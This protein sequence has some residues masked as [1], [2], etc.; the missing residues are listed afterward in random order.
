MSNTINNS[1]NLQEILNL[2]CIK[3]G[4]NPKPAGKTNLIRCSAH[5]DKAPSLAVSQG[6]DGK[7][8]FY[9][10]ADCSPEAICASIGIS[11]SDLFPNKPPLFKP[12]I[13]IKRTE[14]PYHDE[15]GKQLFSKIRLEPG[16]NGQTKTFFFEHV[17]NGKMVRSLQDCRKV[18]YRLP[19]VLNGIADQKTIFLVEGEKD[20]DN[21][22]KHGLI[23]TAT[24]S[25]TYW[26]QEYTEILANANV[27]ILFDYD[28]TGIKRRDILCKELFDKVKRLRVFDLP[29]L[30]LKDSHG[31][32]ISDWLNKKDN[33][34][35]QFLEMIE[36]THDYIPKISENQIHDEIQAGKIK[37]ISF[38]EFLQLDLPKPE[39]L[40]TPFLWSQGLVLLYAKRGVGKTHIALGIA[41]AVASGGNFLKWSAP[42]PK[43]VLYIDGEMPAFSMQGRLRKISLDD[44]E[45]PT[46]DYLQF[47]TPDLQEKAMPNLSTEEGRNTIEEFIKDCDLV[48]IDNLS[49]LFRS[50][51]ENE[52][53]SWLPIQEWALELRRR[54]KCVLFVHHAGKSGQQ[55]GTSKKEDLLDVIISLKQPDDYQPEEGANFEIHFEKTRHFAGKDAITFQVQLKEHDDGTWNWEILNAGNNPEV[56]EIAQMMEQKATINQMMAQTGLSKSQIETRMKKAKQSGLVKRNF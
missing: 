4:S 40:L 36:A 8:L 26:N 24:H 43:K 32:D 33:T 46:P 12:P 38:D 29:G 22:V 17:E 50:G 51:S 53:E 30:E 20:A 13:Q 56:L 47:I 49:S 55:R 52:A 31:E 15:Q 35:A 6:D 37:A 18:L 54:G 44:Q 45:I 2:I 48:I 14:Y 27:V 3:T 5:P 10:H 25:S 34:I 28:K 1:L 11:M 21:L 16:P 39:M 42:E 19:E 23:A 7:I 9:C 41:Y